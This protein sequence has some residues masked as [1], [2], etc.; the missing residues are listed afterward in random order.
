MSDKIG[1]SVIVVIKGGIIAKLDTFENHIESVKAYAE[2]ASLDSE[3]WR[4]IKP[5]PMFD[6][7]KAALEQ[8]SDLSKVTEI[9]GGLHEIE[10]D[11]NQ[12]KEGGWVPIHP[13]MKAVPSLNPRAH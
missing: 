2:A 10:F 13:R 4:E 9:R 7:Y 11:D 5:D 6:R 3:V 1:I 8:I 12:I